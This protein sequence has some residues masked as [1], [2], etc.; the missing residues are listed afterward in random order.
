VDAL[1]STDAWIA[2]LSLTAMEIVLGIDNIVFITILVGRVSEEKRPRVRRIGLIGAL[3]TRLGLLFALSAIMKLTKPM[4]EPLG[5]P[6]S[7]RDLILL[8]GGL[9]LIFKATLEIHH[10]LEGGGEESKDGKAKARGAWLVIIQ[11]MI[12]DIVFSLDSVITAV[13]MASHLWV[14]V[15]A[16]IIA[17]GVMLIFAGAI[18]DFVERHPSIKIL[19]LSFLLLIGVLL[20]AEGLGQ[21]IEK[22]YVYFAM[23]FSLTV[24]LLNIRRTRSLKPVH[25]RS[26]YEEPPKADA[27]A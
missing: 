21:H 7:G 26:P 12:I 22:G 13:G 19:A 23:A 1:A 18:G 5:H 2:L 11:I 4:W 15:T 6:L 8:G 14:M 16:M 25:L 3:V 9:F 24:E 17:V 27:A 20:V 10:K